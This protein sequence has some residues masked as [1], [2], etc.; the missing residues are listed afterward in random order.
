MKRVLST[1]T[2]GLPF[3]LDEL[4]TIQNNVKTLT[5]AVGK[6]LAIG[7]TSLKV[8]GID[9]VITDSGGPAPT[10]DIS[11]GTFWYLDE[12]YFFDA[13]VSLSL[14]S[15]MTDATFGSTYEFDLDETT[16]TTVTFN[17][18]SSKDI[19]QLRKTVLTDS[20]ATWSGLTYTSALSLRDNMHD[21]FPDATNSIKGKLAIATA[22]EVQTGTNT[23]KAVT[24]STISNTSTTDK[25][26]IE[27]ATSAEV[28]DGVD[29]IRAVTPSTLRSR[30]TTREIIIDISDW[31]MQANPSILVSHS[32]PDILKVR[33]IDVMIVYD[34]GAAVYPRMFPLNKITT[35]VEG[36]VAGGVF[37][38]TPTQI[39]L[40]RFDG[41]IFDS[42]DFNDTSYNRGWITIR[43]VD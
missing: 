29:A 33:G 13:V 31:N 39:S 22:A 19:V 4:E 34:V 42:G 30:L 18:A 8:E 14:P 5:A 38:I 6:G 10:A 17:D 23:T 41:A 25:G 2:G 37:F 11:A 16:N 7:E 20:P 27:I 9:A 32:I 15:G 40:E 3:T 43:Y 1:L 28:S 36:K 21:K 24:S 35:N 26:I 12:L